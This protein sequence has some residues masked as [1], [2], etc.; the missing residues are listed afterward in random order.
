M[1]LLPTPDR[2]G[3][4]TDVQ[5]LEEY[6]FEHFRSWHLVQDGWKTLRTEGIRPGEL[7]PDFAVSGVDGEPFRLSE[8][9]G[10]PVLLRFGSRT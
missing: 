3:R 1:A 7:A 6:N 9:R 4:R 8:L 2:S 5:S 10:L